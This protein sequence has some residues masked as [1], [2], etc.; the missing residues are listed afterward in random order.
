[1]GYVH[2]IVQAKA[3]SASKY[4]IQQI[5][6][7]IS[8]YLMYILTVKITNESVWRCWGEMGKGSEDGRERCSLTQNILC[9][10]FPAKLLLLEC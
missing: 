10:W 1:M 4:L 9:G 8:F 6:Y 5:Y 2:L 7:S 3:F